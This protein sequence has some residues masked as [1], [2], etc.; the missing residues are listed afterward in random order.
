MNIIVNRI[1]FE[2]MERE[3]YYKAINLSEVAKER[4]ESIISEVEDLFDI[5]ISDVLVGEISNNT[6]RDFT[7]LWLFDNYYIIECKE[8]MS[9]NDFDFLAMNGMFYV[10]INRI[11]YLN[12]RPIDGS[13]VR[14]ET[15]SYGNASCSLTAVGKNCSYAEKIMKKYFI[16]NIKKSSPVNGHSDV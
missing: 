14:I 9:K 2:S 8:F 11:G 5:K 10:N 7:S 3:E 16:P 1:K 13:K 12:R 4:V 15:S 6:N